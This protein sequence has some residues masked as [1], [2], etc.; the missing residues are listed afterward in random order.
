MGFSWGS[1]GHRDRA[2]PRGAASTHR[3][4]PAKQR[5]SHS[6]SLFHG[7]SEELRGEG[8]EQF[9]K[10][11]LFIMRSFL[12]TVDQDR[13]WKGFPQP[14]QGLSRD[15][16]SPMLLQIVPEGGGPCR[17]RRCFSQSWS[18]HPRRLLVSLLQEG[19]YPKGKRDLVLFD[20]ITH[21]PGKSAS[22]WQDPGNFRFA[23]SHAM[24][25]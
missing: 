3:L 17:M 18:L 10:S 1:P 13:T 6:Q 9:E 19:L 20:I 21:S 2:A 25:F 14:V 22:G 7:R 5:L 11:Q 8:R 15:W 24:K 12:L 4:I 16:S 23:R